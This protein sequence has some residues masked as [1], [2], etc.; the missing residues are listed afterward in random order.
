LKLEI[1]E[2]MDE[3]GSGKI[4]NFFPDFLPGALN[5][6]SSRS[7]SFIISVGKEEFINPF[8]RFLNSPGKNAEMP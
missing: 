5:S 3:S 1:D 6:F 4:F 8:F 7:A 2:I